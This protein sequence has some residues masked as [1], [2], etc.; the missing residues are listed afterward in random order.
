MRLAV[1]LGIVQEPSDRRVVA[2]PERVTLGEVPLDEEAT[3]A[4][5]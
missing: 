4:V 5:V 2:F 3:E 1:R